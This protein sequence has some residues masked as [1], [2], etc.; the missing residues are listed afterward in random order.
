MNKY[1]ICPSCKTK[2]EPTLFECI[3]CEADLTRVKVTDDEMVKT[4]ESYSGKH[5]DTELVRICE[6]GK[7]N[8]P[9]ARKC[10]LCS[11]DISDI[12]PTPDEKVSDTPVT[13]ILSSL[14]GL[15]V[16]KITTNKVI[17]GRESMMSDYLSGKK[18]VS[19]IHAG[20]TI[21]NGELYIENLSKT[22]YT[23]VNNIRIEQKTK[24]SDGD[25]IG[26]GGTNIDGNSQ[27]EAAYFLVRIVQCM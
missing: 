15:Y 3:N 26:M 4:Q 20:F 10:S 18:Y 13:Y 7:K 16:Y 24:L 17:V 25:V 5:A 23:Y 9:N 8:P 22:N 1:K 14:D 2:N 19:R 21:S 27:P 11:E 6:C 12:S